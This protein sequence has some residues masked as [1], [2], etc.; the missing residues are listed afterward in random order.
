MARERRFKIAGYGLVLL[1][2]R[3]SDS[4]FS[5]VFSGLSGFGL[6]F[7]IGTS[8]GEAPAKAVGISRNKVRRASE[9]IIN[10]SSELD[11][12]VLVNTLLESGLDIKYTERVGQQ[13]LESQHLHQS[14]GGTTSRLRPQL[15]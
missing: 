1:V 15:E 7:S 12:R 2:L 4:V 5:S 11:G 10:R 9:R 13:L 14:V 6:G 8:I 3:S